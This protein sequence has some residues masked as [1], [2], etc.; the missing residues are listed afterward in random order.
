MD[1]LLQLLLLALP[2]PAGKLCWPFP[3]SQG[4]AANVSSALCWPGQTELCLV[5]GLAAEVEGWHEEAVT[6]YKDPLWGAQR[7]LHCWGQGRICEGGLEHLL[8]AEHDP[9]PALRSFLSCL[10]QT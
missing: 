9:K 10:P 1:F 5:T 4:L 7:G 3:S 2:I 6:G 8:G